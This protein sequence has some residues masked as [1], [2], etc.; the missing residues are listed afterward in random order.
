M[1]ANFFWRWRDVLNFEQKTHPQVDKFFFFR[2]NFPL[3]G[4]APQLISTIAQRLAQRCPGEYKVGQLGCYLA[5][6]WE[7][8]RIH[9]FEGSVFFFKQTFD[10]GE[11]MLLFVD[12][13]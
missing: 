10:P 13:G 2:Q 3:G 4:L 6:R 7:V 11:F 9:F 5:P 1:Q 12:V 8:L